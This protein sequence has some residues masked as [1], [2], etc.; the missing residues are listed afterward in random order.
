MD[1]RFLRT[2]TEAY[3]TKHGLQHS[4]D[5]NEIYN[6]L[7]SM[8]KEL[9]E[10]DIELYHQ[11]YDTNLMQKVRIIDSYLEHIYGSDEVLA[12]DFGAAVVAGGVMAILTYLYRDRIT[13][14]IL[15][16]G[17]DIG[18]GFTK[19]GKYLSRKGRYWTFRYAI[20]Q[21]NA[22]K[23][24]RACGVNEKDI[25]VWHYIATKH[26]A[27]IGSKDSIKEGNCLS[28]CYIDYTIETISL[29]AKSYFVCLKKTGDFQQ[30]LNA[31][32]DDLL[33]MLSG[34]QLSASCKDYYDLMR[35]AFDNFYVLLD[36][37]YGKNEIK[38]KKKITELRSK[39]IQ[40]RQFIAKQNNLQQFK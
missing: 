33:N 3:I 39:L 24:Y 37:V 10:N 27:I 14:R 22:A 7:Y 9:R 20:I 38:K 29:L 11:L 30:A 36:Y 5:V 31:R 16:T 21:Q 2:T 40:S 6:D 34:L 1:V 12:E 26:D 32:P 8:I 13:K 4:L 25:T 35:E 28:I 18:E 23:C 15:K 19:V 17:K